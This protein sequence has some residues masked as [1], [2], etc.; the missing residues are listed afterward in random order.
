MILAKE[1]ATLDVLSGGRLIFG[2]GV[3]YVE[4]EFEALGVPFED[5][6]A[7]TEEYLAAIRAIWT[8]EHPASTGRMFSFGGVQAHPH[9]LQRPH[10]PVVMGGYAPAVMSR[11]I[12][13]ADGW[14]GWGLDLDATARRLEVLRET[15]ARVPRGEDLGRLE[16]TIT[17]PA[18]VDVA[19]AA[20]FAE[21]GVDRLN[22][23]LPWSAGKAAV[24]DF[25]ARV[26][27]P[28]VE[29]SSG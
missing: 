1:L 24:D 21:L 2:I 27:R 12:R 7:R 13:E 26:V 4:R 22:L 29:A 25:F 17:P 18:D 11:T 6:G 28:L 8:E 14:Y 23:M 10:P 19:M 15:A 9:P 5:R 3:G 16:I 20:R